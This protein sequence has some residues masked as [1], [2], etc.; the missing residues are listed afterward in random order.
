MTTALTPPTD[1][2]AAYAERPGHFDEC[3]AP[4][5]SLRPAWAEFFKHL[6]PDPAEAIRAAA[7]ACRRAVL[8]QDVSMNVYAGD[9]SNA[10]VWPLDPIPLLLDAGDWSRITAGLK[11]RARLFNVL[12]NDLYGPQNL[13]RSGQLPAAL[14]MANPH[15]LR[16]CAGLGR[17]ASGDDDAAPF[18]HTYAADIARAPDGRWWVIE[19]RLDA[20]SGLGYSLQN[21]IITR[22]V[23]P[24]VF[25]RA[26][27]TRLHRFFQHFRASLENLARENAPAAAAPRVVILSPGPANE[28]YY[29]HA[30]LARYLGY[31]LVEGADLATRDGGVFLRTVGGLRRVDVIVRRVDSDFCDPL[32]LQENSLLGVPGLID[33]ARS[34]TVVIANLPGGRAFETT[35]LLAFLEPLCRHVLG[36]PLALPSVATWWCGHDDARAYVLENLHGL[37]IKPAFPAPGA[38]PL[39][40]G[41]A[42]SDDARAALA[43]EIE[44]RPWASCGQERVLLGTTP[45]LD[46]AEGRLTAMP[47]IARIHL[48]WHDGDYEV[49][50]GGLARCNATGEDTI[51]SLQTGSV[52]K[53]IWV[54]APAPAPPEFHSPDAGSV[55][56]RVP[57]SGAGQSYPVNEYSTP[58]RLADDLFW[59]GRYLERSGQLARL[60]ARLEPL[61]RDEIVTLDPS[62]A[63]DAVRL[64]CHLQQI[65][66]PPPDT[67]AEKSAA[68]IRRAAADPAQ[69]GGLSANMARLA[70]N[71]EAVKSWLPPEAWQIARRLREPRHASGGAAGLRAQLAALDGLL[72]E[73][74]P[75]NTAWH[76]LDLGRRIER[77]AF[78]AASVLRWL[79]T[80]GE[81]ARGLHYQALQLR[82]ALDALPAHP[83]PRAVEQLRDRALYHL[84]I[85]RLADITAFAARPSTAVPFWQTLTNLNHD[86]GNRLTQIYFSHATTANDE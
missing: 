74:L 57:A 20:P 1:F 54:L 23:L 40:Y 31:P 53:D 49:M 82:A 63:D 15:Y 71:L 18:L 77:G 46:P 38:A 69:P 29:E 10:H 22:E 59:L 86:L 41:P 75:R 73:N 72:S 62:V 51:V 16:P 84:S 34:R 35:A 11:Q 25:R 66:A 27:V 3:R 48:A 80:E 76:F 7:E 67:A 83:A 36:E 37:V 52:A 61:L 44:L 5:G 42:L 12:L 28:T 39:H 64:L 55:S 68:L 45:G 65:P 32:E 43:R 47:F 4:D 9:E 81:N 8:E 17:P 78:H 70:R 26:P 85:I 30:Y 58:S 56:P 14:A 19:D 50:P 60:L 21:R 33:A 6:G 24:G 79:V 2:L 13:L